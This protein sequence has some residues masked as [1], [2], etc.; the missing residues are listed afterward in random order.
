[1]SS[2]EQRKIEQQGKARRWSTENHS[3]VSDIFQNTIHI[4]L[5]FAKPERVGPPLGRDCTSVQGKGGRSPRKSSSGANVFLGMSNVCVV[6]DSRLEGNEPWT[7]EAKV[8]QGGSL[9][10]YF[11]TSAFVRATV[12]RSSQ[13]T[14]SR[15]I[16][17]DTSTRRD[18][19]TQGAGV[20]RRLAGQAS[21][22]DFSLAGTLLS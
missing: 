16:V 14:A 4:I 3:L 8:T 2:I 22:S 9:R 12:R 11:F 21:Q 19:Q 20:V 10:L 18:P 5:R 17:G 15:S 6:V 7:A 13:R 1:M